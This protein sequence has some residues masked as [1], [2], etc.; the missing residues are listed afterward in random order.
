MFRNLKWRTH[1]QSH[2]IQYSNGF[3]VFVKKEILLIMKIIQFANILL[4]GNS[5]NIVFTLFPIMNKMRVTLSLLYNRKPF[6]TYIYP[7]FR[8]FMLFS[9]V[10]MTK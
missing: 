7:F 9:A 10:V 8:K 4:T 5:N 6:V 1:R 2:N 3:F